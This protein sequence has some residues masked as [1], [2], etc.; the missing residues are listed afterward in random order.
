MSSK[1]QTWC[2]LVFKGLGS[3]VGKIV[4]RGFYSEE[5]AEQWMD[6]NMPN[7]IPDYDYRIQKEK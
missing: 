1:E 7:A 4:A 5:E 6:K 3:S 2:V